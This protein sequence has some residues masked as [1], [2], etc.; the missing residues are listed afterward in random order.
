ML[1]VRI[2]LWIERFDTFISIFYLTFI[3]VLG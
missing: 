3:L 2:S 1:V